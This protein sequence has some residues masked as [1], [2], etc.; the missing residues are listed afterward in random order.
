MDRIGPIELGEE[1]FEFI[2]WNRSKTHISGAL[3]A[4]HGASWGQAVGPICS[5]WLRDGL[6][7]DL[8]AIVFSW[9][10]RPWWMQKKG[11][12]RPPFGSSKCLLCAGT[13]VWTCRSHGV[14]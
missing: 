12:S 11:D 7:R 14:V 1:V 4:G 5:L 2:G 13:D 10:R 3:L 6:H 8:R 9:R